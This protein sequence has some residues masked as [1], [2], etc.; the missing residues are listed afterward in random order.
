MKK[1][2]RFLQIPRSVRWKDPPVWGF[3]MKGRL[4]RP[5]TGSRQ[6]NPSANGAVNGMGNFGERFDF[7]DRGVTAW[8]ARWGLLLLRISVG[9]IFFWFGVLKFFPGFSPAETLATSTIEVMTGGLVAPRV[10]LVILAA[11]ETLIGLG[12][13]FGK[14]LRATL[15]LLFLQMPGTISPMFLFPELTFQ[16]FPFVLTIEG[17][18]IVKN[19]VLISA[20]IVIGATVRGG[21]LVTEEADPT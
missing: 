4:P 18:Y 17:Q 15:F 12:L 20:G 14:A 13:I 8:M 3:L 21:G 1:A 6:A 2:K 7:F 9:I 11:W 16:Q 19:L 5:D 10:A